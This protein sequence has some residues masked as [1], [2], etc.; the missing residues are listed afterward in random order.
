MNIHE[1]P[2]TRIAFVDTVNGET[3][4]KCSKKAKLQE[5]AGDNAGLKEYL[6][7]LTWEND[8]T[9][10]EVRTNMLKLNSNYGQRDEE[11]YKCGQRETTKHT[12]E[13]KGRPD[14]K[15]T[16]ENYNDLLGKGGPQGN[17]KRLRETAEAIRSHMERRSQIKQIINKFG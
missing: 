11:C 2:R 17:L 9:V 6:K 12:F 15:L 8:R 7:C 4:E 1:Q 14:D 10:F 13:C 16:P 3:L 5:I